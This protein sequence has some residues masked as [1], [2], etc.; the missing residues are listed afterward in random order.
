MEKNYEYEEDLDILYVSNNPYH[1]KPKY[2]LVKENIVI[3]VGENGKI[4]GVEI[5]CASRFFDISY[6]QFEKLKEAKIKIIKSGEMIILGIFL[7]TES[8][9][10]RFQFEIPRD[11]QNKFISR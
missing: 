6:D 1:E 5:D 10:H 11:Y 7:S 9:E 2:D 3:G 8:K 4:L